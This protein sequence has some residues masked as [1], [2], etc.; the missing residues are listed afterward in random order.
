MKKAAPYRRMKLEESNLSDIAVNMDSR[1]ESYFESLDPGMPEWLEQIRRESLEGGIPIIREGTRRILSFF[2]R[3]TGAD[4]ILEVGTATGFSALAM[5]EASGKK[6]HITTI[7]KYE[8]RIPIAKKNFME[9]NASEYITLLEEDADDALARLEGSFDVVF[10]DAAKAQYLQWLPDVLRLLRKGG[11]LISD[12]IMHDGDILES[13]YAVRRRD[14]T[15]HSRMRDY[16]YEL[17]HRDDL[18][19]LILAEGDGTAV[20]VKL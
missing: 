6:A 17:T 1:L 13:R 3:M 9:C 19:T 4:K 10:M 2:V 16:L 15:I 5:W 8:K 18:N 11:L 20:T 12:N 14:R 7:E